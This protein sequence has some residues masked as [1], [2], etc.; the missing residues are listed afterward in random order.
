MMKVFKKSRYSSFCT[1][2]SHFSVKINHEGNYFHNLEIVILSKNDSGSLMN[3]L[4]VFF[5]NRINLTNVETTLINSN[6]EFFEYS[7][8]SGIIM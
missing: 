4:R 6:N 7:H 3:I 5:E 2:Q 1:N 8:N